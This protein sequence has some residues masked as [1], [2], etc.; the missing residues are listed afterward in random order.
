MWQECL[1]DGDV[2][3]ASAVLFMEVRKAGRAEERAM[4]FL[5]GFRGD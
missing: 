4:T 3:P 2:E 1:I 5:E